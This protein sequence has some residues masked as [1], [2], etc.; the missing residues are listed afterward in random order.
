M[1]YKC[2][3][4][5]KDAQFEA[6]MILKKHIKSDTVMNFISFKAMYILLHICISALS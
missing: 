2:F 4:V 6:S 1:W 3:L 5:S